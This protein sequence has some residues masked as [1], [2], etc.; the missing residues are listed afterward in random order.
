MINPEEIKSNTNLEKTL[1]IKPEVL[2]IK[3]PEAPKIE[4][5]P[6]KTEKYDPLTQQFLKDQSGLLQQKTQVDVDAARTKLGMEAA[7]LGLKSNVEKQYATDIRSDIDAN[8]LKKDEYPRPEF[9]PTKENLA[10]LG[11]LFS[12]VSTLGMIVGSSGKMG[13]NNAMNAMTGMLKGWQAGRKDLYEKEVKEFDKEYKR[14]TDLRNEIEKQL[15]K[16]IQLRGIDKEAAYAAGQQAIALAGTNSVLGNMLNKGNVE[17]ALQLLNSGLTVD[18]K[19]KEFQQKEEKARQDRIDRNKPSNEFLIK[20]DGSVTVI[21][22]N[23]LTSKV[24]AADTEFARSIVGGQKMGAS[25]GAGPKA[26]AK[27]VDGFRSKLILNEDLNDLKKDL[28]DPDMVKLLKQYRMEAFLTEEGKA[29]NQVINSGI[30]DKLQAFLTRVRDIRNNYYLD[31]SGKAVTG[32]EALRSYGTVPQPGDDARTMLNKIDGMQKRVI[33][34]ISFDQQ[35]YKFPDIKVNGGE[36]TNLT[37]NELYKTDANVQTEPRT[38]TY[39]LN[40]II[41]RGNKKYKVV[42]IDDPLNPGIEEIK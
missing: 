13:A 5:P 38:S 3:F 18:F 4:V 40:Q 20:P 41:T 11:A 16:S 1:N 6:L 42:N 17:G 23:T 29:L 30:P 2:P 27:A 9:H 32:G 33:N 22:K 36:L 24:F 35:F 15:E 8:Q 14:I 21:D 25:G 19:V 12:M 28:S 7:N 39:Q 34:Q 37:P 26:T 31:I 10:S